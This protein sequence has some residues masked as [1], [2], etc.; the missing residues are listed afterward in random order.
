MSDIVQP[1]GAFTTD[2]EWELAR[3][4]SVDTLHGRLSVKAGY[5]SDG[6][7]IPR[8]LWSCVGPRY[9]PDTFPAAFAHDALYSAELPIGGDWR[10]KADAS[11]RD[12]LGRMGVSW[13]KRTAYWLA[14][15]AAGWLVA[16]Q[17]T[18][19]S[20]FEARLLIRLETDHA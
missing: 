10:A 4:W 18:P 9:A 6:A 17:H 16:A 1:M 19:E 3:D 12:L 20:I 8:I 7:S 11:F 5:L 14:V 15:R 13:I 2:N